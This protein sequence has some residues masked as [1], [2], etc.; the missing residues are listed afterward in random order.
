M[1]IQNKKHTEN[2][3]VSVLHIAPTPFFSDRG[4]HMRIN[5]IISALNRRG[6]KNVL[7]TYHHGRD[8]PGIDTVRIAR[9]PGYTKQEAGP[10]L[11]KYL[12]DV[13]LWIKVCILLIKTRPDIIHGHLHEGAL[14]GWGAK[15]LLFWRKIPLVFDVQG[16]LVG[17]LDAHGYFRRSTFLKRIFWFVEYIITRLPRFF[18]CSSQSSIAILNTQFRVP[19]ERIALVNDG[20][21]MID[22]AGVQKRTGTEIDLPKNIPIAIYAG[23][24]LESKGLSTLY[25]VLRDAKRRRLNC[26]FLIVGYPEQPMIDFIAKHDLGN[27][28]KVV[29]RVPFEALPGYLELASVAIEPKSAASGEASGKILNYMAAGLPVVC[30][31]TENNRQILGECGYFAE[32]GS[33]TCLVDLL[34]HVLDAPEEAARRGIAARARVR[35]DF[36]WDSGAA[37]ICSAYEQLLG[38]RARNL[39]DKINISKGAK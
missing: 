15:T 17:E 12:A 10:T 11:F 26:Y 16:S 9:I 21:D 33:A 28:C 38:S 7:C 1:T 8:M 19:Q 5:G 30:F 22:Q 32:R 13:L 35:S 31:D 24:L 37:T 29:G 3:P 25:E 14:I 36:S 6:I 34:Q 18:I 2:R 39:A 27:F 23:A 4:C 20:L